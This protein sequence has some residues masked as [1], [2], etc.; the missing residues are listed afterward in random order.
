MAGS[1]SRLT[2]FDLGLQEIHVACLEGN[3][4]QVIRLTC[5]SRLPETSEHLNTP[6]CSPSPRPAGVPHWHGE[7]PL[8]LAA[9]MGHLHVVELLLQLGA[10]PETKDKNGYKAKDLYPSESAFAANERAVFLSH[11]IGREA[12]IAESARGRVFELLSTPRLQKIL[13][14]T[15]DGDPPPLYL[16]K[17]GKHVIITGP[18]MKINT[19]FPLTAEKTIGCVRGR[20]SDA[21][22]GVAISGFRGRPDC[23]PRCLDSEQW[24]DRTLDMAR[25]IGFDFPASRNDQPGQKKELLE[26]QFRGRER[27][28]HCECQLIT[29]YVVRVMEKY[30]GPSN[31]HRTLRSK[32]RLLGEI[33]MGDD[34][35]AYISIS[36]RP[37]AHCLQYQHSISHITGIAFLIKPDA[38]CGFTRRVKVHTRKN[39]VDMVFPT[40][41]DSE[42]EDGLIEDETMGYRLAY[43]SRQPAALPKAVFYDTPSKQAHD[44][45]EILE[46]LKK[47][48]PVYHFPGYETRQRTRAAAEETIIPSTNPWED[49][50]SSDWDILD[51][52]E[53]SPIRESSDEDLSKGKEVHQGPQRLEGYS[54]AL[55]D[56]DPVDEVDHRSD[57]PEIIEISSSDS[58]GFDEFLNDD[59]ADEDEDAGFAIPTPTPIRF[60]NPEAG[61]VVPAARPKHTSRHFVALSQSRKRSRL[62]AQQQPRFEPPIP[63]RS[64]PPPPPTTAAT[65]RPS[66]LVPTSSSVGKKS[67]TRLMPSVVVSSDAIGQRSRRLQEWRYQPSPR[68]TEAQNQASD[69][70]SVFQ[71]RFPFLRSKFA[72]H[73]DDLD[74]V[75]ARLNQQDASGRWY[76]I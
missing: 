39:A 2:A 29:F 23:D 21:V 68:T 20:N 52:N 70:G 17:Q 1:S 43:Q 47:K 4:E 67:P 57:T 49:S 75:I 6:L 10:D 55:I 25:A 16:M 72:R 41:G 22:L 66:R 32:L 42:D 38:G 46:R 50:P 13:Q 31:D 65:T 12:P 76:Q 7:T 54:F 26:P 58:G 61:A 64:K 11:G 3:Y 51:E 62:A 34:R 9:L 18:S 60:Y 28:G 27:A 40:L 19:V 73:D 53:S 8:M 15:G 33:N 5:T 69:S 30:L 36:S 71:T 48:T 14:R 35:M 74:P 37:C 59:H 56:E 24:T 45:D 44:H 63:V